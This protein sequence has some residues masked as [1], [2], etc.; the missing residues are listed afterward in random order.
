M[1][2]LV[3]WVRQVL[4]PKKSGRISVNDMFATFK[5]ILALN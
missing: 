5:E 2:H 3:E 1:K 4:A